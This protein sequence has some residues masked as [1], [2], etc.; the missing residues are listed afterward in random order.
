MN[1]ILDWIFPK[2]KSDIEIV[3]DL[4]FK[5][6]VTNILDTDP[7]KDQSFNVGKNYILQFGDNDTICQFKVVGDSVPM[8]I[9][10]DDDVPQIRQS[11]IG[12]HSAAVS[13]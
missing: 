8:F 10:Q 11:V 3:N 4:I 2:Q 9:F 7:T 6:G 1:K 5:H 12:V 13:Q